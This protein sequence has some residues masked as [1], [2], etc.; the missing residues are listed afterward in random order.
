MTATNSWSL[1]AFTSSGST[2]T[3]DAA[4]AAALS[5]LTGSA[6]T[7]AVQPNGDLLL[8]GQASSTSAFFARYGA[9]SSA[10][11]VAGAAVE[12]LALSFDGA[13]IGTAIQY[14]GADT[15][16][17]GGSPARRSRAASPIRARRRRPTR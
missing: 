2:L 8:A 3:L 12:D 6:A 14:S 4:F 7:L 10:A 1:A 5:G 11:A 13:T 16:D 9:D 15:Q 17:G